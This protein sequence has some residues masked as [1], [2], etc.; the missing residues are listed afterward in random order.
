EPAR[1]TTACRTASRRGLT[2]SS[3]GMRGKTAAPSGTSGSAASLISASGHG[4]DDRQLVAVL[5]RRGQVVQV[6]DVLVVDVQVDEAA[7]LAVVEDALRQP[8]E[9][10]S[11]VVQHRLDRVARGL[12]SGLALGVLPHRRGNLNTNRHDSSLKKTI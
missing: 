2:A 9:A 1:K 8:G 11:E 5:D 3:G 4:G 12:H 7:H 6:A 10:G